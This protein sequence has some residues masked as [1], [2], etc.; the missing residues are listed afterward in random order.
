[1]VM[2][3]LSTKGKVLSV[4]DLARLKFRRYKVVDYDDA[5]WAL[6][7]D[8]L[9]FVEGIK[10]QTAH[11]AAQSLSRRLKTRVT[12]EPVELDGVKGYVFIRGDFESW[13]AR[14]ARRSSKSP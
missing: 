2:S 1:M 9:Y 14:L 5:V 8:L 4:Q 10:R 6:R 11:K 13:A 12:A 7:R 3:T